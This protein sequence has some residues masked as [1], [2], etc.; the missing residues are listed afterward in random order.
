MEDFQTFVATQRAELQKKRAALAADINKLNASI[1]EIDREM[2]AIQAY[3]NAKN[4]K[5]APTPT[6][7]RTRRGGVR[8]TVLATIIESG[9]INR[10]DL[11]VKLDAKGDTKAEQSISNAL[12]NLK[13][14]GTITASD[15]T[16]KAV[17]G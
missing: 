10:S 1:A 7:T 12:A 11:L 15:G 14:A 5:V 2:L 4:G 9:G 13:K 17:A 3:E 8:D 16:Y 6:G